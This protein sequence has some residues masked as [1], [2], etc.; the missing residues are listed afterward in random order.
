MNFKEC[1][2]CSCNFK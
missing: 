2:Y 1:K